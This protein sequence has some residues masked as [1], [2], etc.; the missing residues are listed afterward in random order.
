MRVGVEEV[1]AADHVIAEVCRL[2]D[3]DR[4]DERSSF[5]R[6]RVVLGD[7]LRVDVGERRAKHRDLHVPDRELNRR[8]VS[9]ELVHAGERLDCRSHLLPPHGFGCLSSKPPRSQRRLSAG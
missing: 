2:D 8:V 4:L 7:E 9:V 5:E 1:R 3:R 6:D